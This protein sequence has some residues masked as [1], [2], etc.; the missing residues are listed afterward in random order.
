MIFYYIL[1]S[2]EE[3]IDGVFNENDEEDLD[4]EEIDDMDFKDDDEE[5][6]IKNAK[7]ISKKLKGNDTNLSVKVRRDPITKKKLVDLNLVKH[8]FNVLNDPIEKRAMLTECVKITVDCFVAC[9][10]RIGGATKKKVK[11]SKE[12]KEKGKKVTTSSEFIVNCDKGKIFCFYCFLDFESYIKILNE[13][14]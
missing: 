10:E 13:K 7:K 12:K 4:S 9:L 2:V 1:F 8:L 14:I 5:N 3:E 11:S 6:V